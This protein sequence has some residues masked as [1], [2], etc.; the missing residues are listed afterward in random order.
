[1]KES[2]D[3]LILV[4]D[5]D[6]DL[7]NA[8]ASDFSRKGFQTLTAENGNVALSIVKAKKVDVI[9]S[10]VRMP[11]GDGVELL[12]NV[13]A[14]NIDMPVMMFITGFADIGKD[15]AY[16]MG[17]DAIFEKP[18]NR[19]VLM[20]TVLRSALS[21]QEAWAK[22]ED[23]ANAEAKIEI[24]FSEDS[25]MLHAKL[26]NIGR[27]GAFILLSKEFPDVGSRVGFKMNFAQ[28]PFFKIEG[29]GIVRWV[30]KEQSEKLPAGCG[31][32]FVELEDSCRDAILKFLDQIKTKSFIPNQ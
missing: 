2:K 22:R 10:D 29:T 9:L 32:E 28:P 1:M 23:R 31:V 30:R 11:G 6:E 26:L 17:A 19:K 25:P 14:L 13:K 21:K 8:I 18:F 3:M 12:K 5:D 4:V 20:D 16:Q 7:R 15:E 27:G 24:Q